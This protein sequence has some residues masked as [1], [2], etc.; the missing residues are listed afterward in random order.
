[1][2]PGVRFN[3]T[4]NMLCAGLANPTSE[5]GNNDACQGDSGGP[6][7]CNGTLYGVV[8]SGYQCGLSNFPGIYSKVSAVRSWIRNTTG[9]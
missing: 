2:V 8:S 9:V 7:V 1:M 6:L 4:E 5:E 3:V